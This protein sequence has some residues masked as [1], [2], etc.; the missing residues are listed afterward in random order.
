[1][2][3]IK[4]SSN[5]W[6]ISLP[7]LLLFLVDIWILGKNVP[8]SD[9]IRYWQTASDILNGFRSTTVLESSLLL[10]GPL[11]P[12]ILAIFKLIGFS[13]KASIFLNAIFLYVGFTFFLKSLL[14]FLTLKK[15]ICIGSSVKIS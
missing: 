15:S 11:Y 3:N 9:G 6:L 14:Y 8:V 13:V 4:I 2:N 1:M 7:I 10:N 5:P 12:T